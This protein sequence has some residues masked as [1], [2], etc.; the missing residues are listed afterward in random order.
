[1]D[2]APVVENSIVLNV[3]DMLQRWSNDTLRSTN[4]RV[5][6]T[7]ITKARYSMPYFVDPGRDVM[8]ENSTDRPPLYQPI[9]AYDYLKWRLAQSYLDDKYQVNEK[10]GIEGKKYIPKE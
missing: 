1:M 3:G 5:V 9:S 7:S 6:N 10:V 8:I 4:H 2:N